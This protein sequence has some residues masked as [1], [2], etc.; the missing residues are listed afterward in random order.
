MSSSPVYKDWNLPFNDYLPTVFF[1]PP[2]KKYT[3][4]SI[5]K[6]GTLS[7]KPQQNRGILYSENSTNKT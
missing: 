4:H 1:I 3:A 7:N 5:N 2:K 6:D